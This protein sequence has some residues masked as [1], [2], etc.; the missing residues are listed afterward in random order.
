M[1]IL[2][3]NSFDIALG[4][5]VD[6]ANEGYQGISLTAERRGE[7]VSFLLARLRVYLLDQ[8]FSYDT[9]DAVLASGEERIPRLAAKVQALEAFRTMPEYGDLHIAYERA[10]NL[11]AKAEGISYNEG[12]FARRIRISSKAL[13]SLKETVG[14]HGG[15]HTNLAL[16]TLARFRPALMCS[17]IRL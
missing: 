8:G 13:S 5:L 1:Q 7:L 17:S 15:V 11:A 12:C 10:A 3:A 14:Q 16:A 2:L 9:V 6:L 4:R